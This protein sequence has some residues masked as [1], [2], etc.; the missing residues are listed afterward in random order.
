M[1]IDINIALQ[2]TKSKI[3]PLTSLQ[4]FSVTCPPS[5]A[6]VKTMAQ[7]VSCSG[8]LCASLGKLNFNDFNIV[9]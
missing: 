5:T 4:E 1:L 3:H 2:L 7:H 8:P 6:S 9:I